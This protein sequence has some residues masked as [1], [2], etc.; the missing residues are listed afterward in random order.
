MRIWP[1]ILTCFLVL[2][3]VI[4]TTRAKKGRIARFNECKEYFCFLTPVCCRILYYTT[5]TNIEFNIEIGQ[6]TDRVNAKA[7]WTI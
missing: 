2:D 4:T 5:H 3:P 7:V 6:G 1:L